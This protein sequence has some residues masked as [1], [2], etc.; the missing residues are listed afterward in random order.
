M[1]ERNILE[2]SSGTNIN[3]YTNTLLKTS[4]SLY[5]SNLPIIPH[6]Y[7]FSD[8][9]YV[10]SAPETSSIICRAHCKMKMQALC[11]EMNKFRMATAEHETKHGALV[12]K[13]PTVTS[14][15]VCP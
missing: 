7:F 2:I 11:L 6:L 1:L 14:Q 15:V 10:T 5:M 8:E 12:S 3:L 4:I 13:W 9:A